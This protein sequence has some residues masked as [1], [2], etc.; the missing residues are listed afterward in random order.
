MGQKSLEKISHW[1]LQED[2]DGLL[3]ALKVVLSHKR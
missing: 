3:Q 2:V 1:G